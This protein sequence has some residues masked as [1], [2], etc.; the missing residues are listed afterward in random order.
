[1]CY[2]FLSW[3]MKRQIKW[4]YEHHLLDQSFERKTW[5]WDYSS[6]LRNK[7]KSSSSFLR[8]TNIYNEN[9]GD[10]VMKIC[11]P[12]DASYNFMIKI[13]NTM[14]AKQMCVASCTCRNYQY[15]YLLSLLSNAINDCIYT[16]HFII[17]HKD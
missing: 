17:M 15:K 16:W 7:M 8:I 12:F 5:Q 13:L 3:V 4:Q 9:I 14:L 11:K 10:S 1:M 6:T 2:W